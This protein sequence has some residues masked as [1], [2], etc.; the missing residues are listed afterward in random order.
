MPIAVPRRLSHA[1]RPE[2]CTVLVYRV[3]RGCKHAGGLLRCLVLI[4]GLW[5]GVLQAQTYPAHERTTVNDYADLLSD[6]DE[7]ALSAQLR[8]LRRDT[9]VEM[10]VLTLEAQAAYAPDMSLERFA[11]GLFNHWGIG[12][13]A[14]NDGV[15]VLVIADDR[16]M[17]VEL[18]EGYG[19]TWDRV[20][21]EVVD[22]V[23]LPAFA[24]DDYAQG[25]RRGSTAVISKIVRPA[26][27]GEDAPEGGGDGNGMWMFG[28][29]AVL[30]LLSNGWRRIGDGLAR[31][32]S[33]PQCHQRGLRQT[34]R[35]TQSATRHTGGHGMKRVQCQHCDY[36]HEIPYTIARISSGRSGGFGGGS[37]G[38]G[39]ASG[40]W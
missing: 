32:R 40:R 22:D 35:V 30:I 15:L 3:T 36:D 24:R 31:F 34:R 28:G 11:T 38:G 25:I 10:T 20:A 6:A 17:R 8:Q 29:F 39:G 2:I 19:R 23:F 26:R 5:A 4:V 16:A 9:G 12:N 37:S 18:G 14:R 27:A 21:R 33:C 1:S 13:A 7:A